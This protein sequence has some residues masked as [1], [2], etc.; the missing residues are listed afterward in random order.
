MFL[1]SCAQSVHNHSGQNDSTLNCSFPVRT[2]AQECERRSDGSQEDYAKDRSHDAAFAA[3][4]R[5]PAHNH[6]SEHQDAEQQVAGTEF[7]HGQRT[8]LRQRN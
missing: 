8:D 2:H 3:C 6:G 5:S 1:Q 4:Y 7:V